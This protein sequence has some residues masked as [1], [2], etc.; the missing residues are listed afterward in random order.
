MSLISADWHTI[1]MRVTHEIRYLAFL[2]LLK[3]LSLL[4]KNRSSSPKLAKIQ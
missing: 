2:T 1:V 4:G 3:V